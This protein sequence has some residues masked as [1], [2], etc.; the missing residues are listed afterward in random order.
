[1]PGLPVVT[2]ETEP[3]AARRR[4]IPGEPSSE[5]EGEQNWGIALALTV[6]PLGLAASA[7]YV[8]L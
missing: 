6:W 2:P 5:T 3:M 7:I 8:I 1:M 4:E